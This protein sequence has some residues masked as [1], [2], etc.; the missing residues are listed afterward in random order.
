M[1]LKKLSDDLTVAAQITVADIEVLKAQ[2]FRS[3]IC[4]RPDGEAPDQPDFSEIEKTALAAGFTLRFVPIYHT[5]IT[6][7]DVQSFAQAMQDLPKPI[8][9]YCRSGTRS[10]YVAQISGC[11]G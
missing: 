4:N 7:E 10:S 5:G 6:P 3:I 9:A 2:G 8:L 1:D 11:L